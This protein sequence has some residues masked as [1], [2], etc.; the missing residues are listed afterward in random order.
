MPVDESTYKKQFAAALKGIMKKL[1]VTREEL[2]EK[3]GCDLDTVDRWLD[4]KG[5]GTL[6]RL[7]HF[8]DICNEFGLSADYLFVPQ[9]YKSGDLEWQWY[10]Q[11]PANA[12]A[13]HIREIREGIAFFEE[14]LAGGNYTRL[15][16][17]DSAGKN[18]CFRVAVASGS[19]QLVSIPRDTKREE[20][21]KKR[22]LLP[23]H[24]VVLVAALPQTETGEWLM[25]NPSVRTEFVA[26]LTAHYGLEKF[27]HRPGAIG[28][29]PGYTILRVMELTSP[30]TSRFVGTKFIP[31][32]TLKVPGDDP[33]AMSPNHTA[34]LMA[35]RHPGAE[36]MHL[37]Y[38]EPNRRELQPPL[39]Q[40]EK[41]V[42]NAKTTL[43]MDAGV[44][45]FSVGSVDTNDPGPIRV[46]QAPAFTA[47]LLQR[48]YQFLGSEV[49]KKEFAGELL[50]LMLNESGKLCGPPGTQAYNLEQVCPLIS[51]D[52]LKGLT[53]SGTNVW[54]VGAGAYKQEAT[55]M[56]LRN[57]F[58]NSLT[59]D[60]EIAEYLIQKGP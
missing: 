50:G 21:I 5:R 25:G 58:A 33:I 8:F 36:I 57:G 47:E 9:S 40:E 12:S 60:A 55:L 6:P 18:P 48:L 17:T 15:S 26:F 34:A 51:L 56:A 41:M 24:S 27:T 53:N 14:C 22:F 42:N 32:I 54:L 37:S 59:I 35:S 11:I 39:S 28:I 23:A 31:L 43:K 52:E 7:S 1:G 2:A 29:G 13:E 19:L 30:S 3:V 16:Q 10:E 49:A 4:E 38:I 46:A 20:L 44:L 45:F